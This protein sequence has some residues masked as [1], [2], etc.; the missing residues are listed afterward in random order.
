M[1]QLEAE[2]AKKEESVNRA[3]NELKESEK[4]RSNLDEMITKLKGS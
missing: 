1:A 3:C 2:L 4:H